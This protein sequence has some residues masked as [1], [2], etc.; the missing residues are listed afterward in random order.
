MIPPGPFKHRSFMM[1]GTPKYKSKD[2]LVLGLQ[3]PAIS[4]GDQAPKEA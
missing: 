1:V 4:C 3:F 2:F